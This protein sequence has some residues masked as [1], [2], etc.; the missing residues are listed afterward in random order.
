MKEVIIHK[1]EG[2]PYWEHI[3]GLS[4]TL[5][6]RL[7]IYPKVNMVKNIGIS[8]NATHAADDISKIPRD[9]RIYFKKRNN[10]INMPLIHPKYMINDVLYNEKIKKIVYPSVFVRYRRKIEGYIL[11][12]L[13]RMRQSY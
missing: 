6:N 2:I 7:V 4:C 12:I 1:A 11:K 5:N 8:K 9:I 10:D 13:H 3:I